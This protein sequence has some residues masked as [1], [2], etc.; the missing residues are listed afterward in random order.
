MLCVLFAYRDC[1]T[2][3]INNNWIFFL[4]ILCQASPDRVL[5]IPHGSRQHNR[6]YAWHFWKVLGVT[7]RGKDDVSPGSDADILGRHPADNVV[8][9]DARTRPLRLHR[10]LDDLQVGQLVAEYCHLPI[11]LEGKDDLLDH[12]PVVRR[13]TTHR[14]DHRRLGDELRVHSTPVTNSPFRPNP[15]DLRLQ[16]VAGCVVDVLP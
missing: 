15:S 3:H 8:D 1:V 7:I 16:Q 10:Q 6:V 5:W 9:L 12:V 13:V 4:W 11:G 2:P 14:V